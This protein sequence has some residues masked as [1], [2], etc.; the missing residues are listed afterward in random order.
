VPLPRGL[1][2]AARELGAARLRCNGQ[3]VI[4]CWDEL[5]TSRERLVSAAG[6]VASF[7]AGQRGGMYR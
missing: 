3:R 1:V 4:L 2:R 7:A 6:L 5:E